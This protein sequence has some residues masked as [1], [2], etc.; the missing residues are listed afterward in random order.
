MGNLNKQ[1]QKQNKKETPHRSFQDAVKITKLDCKFHGG[2]GEQW[3]NQN[4]IPHKTNKKPPNKT[5]TQT[6]EITQTNTN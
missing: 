3:H 5:K 2:R 6:K 4:K 1:K